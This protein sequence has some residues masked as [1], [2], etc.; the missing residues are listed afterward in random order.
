MYDIS[1][2]RVKELN[3]PWQFRSNPLKFD[4]LMHSYQQYVNNRKGKRLKSICIRAIVPGRLPLKVKLGHLTPVC[5]E[6]GWLNGSCTRMFLTNSF[7]FFLTQKPPPWA[8]AFTFLRF[9]DH[10]QRRITVGRTLLDGWSARR[11]DLYLTTHNNH[12]KHTCLGGIRTYN[13]SRGAAVEL[14][15]RPRDHWDRLDILMAVRISIFW[16]V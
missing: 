8:R 14:R 6:T 7:C 2:L 13:L 12:D 4:E 3:T 1:N 16:N 10:T 15:L 11:R 5:S 9:L